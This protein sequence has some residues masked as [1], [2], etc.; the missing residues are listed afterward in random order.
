MKFVFFFGVDGLHLLQKYSP[1]HGSHIEY[2]YVSSVFVEAGGSHDSLRFGLVSRSAASLVGSLFGVVGSLL[3][4]EVCSPA[5]F[6]QAH[7][8]AVYDP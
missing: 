3:G 1:F 5:F 7:A 2:L 4:E 8:P 6:T